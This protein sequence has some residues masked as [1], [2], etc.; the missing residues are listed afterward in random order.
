MNSVF[1]S[2]TQG[3]HTAR[4]LVVVCGKVL[5]VKCLILL[6]FKVKRM[7]RVWILMLPASGKPHTH[8]FDRTYFRHSSST[9]HS[10]HSRWISVMNPIQRPYRVNGKSPWACSFESPVPIPFGCRWLPHH[11]LNARVLRHSPSI[12]RMRFVSRQLNWFEDF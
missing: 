8:W 12:A 4:N 1:P 9:P 7:Q 10:D 3:M 11:L 5:C 2:A 6:D